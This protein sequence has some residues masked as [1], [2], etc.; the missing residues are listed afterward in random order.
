MADQAQN[1]TSAN[2]GT[3][4]TSPATLDDNIFATQFH[5]MAAITCQEAPIETILAEF[6]YAAAEA[7]QAQAAW[8]TLIAADSGTVRTHYSYGLTDL[9]GKSYPLAGSPDDLLLEAPGALVLDLA[10][11]P[12]HASLEGLAQYLLAGCALRAGGQTYGTLKLLYPSG[13][14]IDAA[15]LLALQSAAMLAAAATRSHCLNIE[16]HQLT[17][18]DA[19]T[20]LI[21]QS[22]FL[23]MAGQELRRARRYDH[24]FSLLLVDI[25][26]FRW[27]NETYGHSVGDEVLRDISQTFRENLRDVDILARYGGEEF[28]LLLPETSLNEALG[29][30]GRLLYMLR[31]TPMATSAGEVQITVS[32]GVSGLTGQDDITLDRL[33]DR[34]DRALYQSKK[35]GRNR[36]T[37]WLED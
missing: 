29:V 24:A 14:E 15:R 30:A 13:S 4:S 9:E 18:S 22:Y 10:S 7:L 32:I 35:N 25:D 27:V 12:E 6:A 37:V 21:N 3:S 1:H 31:S 19:L 16:V 5:Q 26:N 17:V 20:G 8:I 28:V 33:L 2:A 34:A 36:V 11:Q 23:D